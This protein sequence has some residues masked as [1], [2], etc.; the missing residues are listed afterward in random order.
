LALFQHLLNRFDKPM[1][2]PDPTGN[3]KR[4]RVWWL[5]CVAALLGVLTTVVTFSVE[6]ETAD[7]GPAETE[8]EVVVETLAPT[9]LA[10]AKPVASRSLRP[11]QV[12][13]EGYSSSDACRECHQNE[14]RS[15]HSSY[16][17]TMTQLID[18]ETAPQAIRNQSV[19]VAGREY[20]F[21]Q[22]GEQ[23]FVTFQDPLA[24]DQVRRRQLL[25]MTGSHHMHVF[26]YET[27]AEG[28][29]GEL[30]IVYLIE[31][32]K[33]IPRLA[34]FLRP[35]GPEQ[36]QIGT[37][38]RTC[39]KCHAT[40][41]R[42]RF[43]RDE[44]SWDTQV[45]E[46]G[47]ACEACHGEGENHIRRHSASGETVALDDRIVNPETLS[48]QAS[49]DVCGRCHSVSMPDFDAVSKETYRQ[50]GNPFK[51]GQLLS[52]C[53]FNCIIQAGPEAREGELF[54]R[55]SSIEDPSGSFWQDG[56]SRVAGREYNG[57]IESPCFQHGGMT[58]LS[59]HTMHPSE[60]QSLD[61]WRD[62]QL[63]PGMRGD[64]ACLQCHADF[65]DRI[66]EHTHHAPGSSGSACMNCHMP[67]TTYGLLKSI[68]SHQITS[69]SVVTSLNTDRPSAC[70]L[71]HLDRPFTWIA[72]RLHDWYDQ[73]EIQIDPNADAAK[74]ST[75]VIHF[76]KGD[77]AQRALQ[78]WSFGWEPAR[79]ASGTDW[80]EPFLLLGA[81][82]PYDAVRIISSRSLRSLP[83]RYSL[84]VDPLS[85]AGQRMKAFNESIPIL[86]SKMK[87]EPKPEVLIDEQGNFDFLRARKLIDQRN[88][89][90]VS[91]RE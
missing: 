43:N 3:P 58:C 32:E 37:W 87:A 57:L 80:M 61:D 19:T 21:E 81:N 60:S 13:P 17:R 34:S 73:P 22:D 24:Q 56:M 44:V 26:W 74:I 35:P 6:D 72:D 63:K 15:W 53:E 90:D 91:I 89:R 79:E 83:K 29:P 78:A 8:Q 64:Q 31:E 65:A 48:K 16:H 71:C 14:H 68:R 9:P 62:D 49:A 39:S 2:A 7:Q 69:P 59:C 36:P 75:A 47:I 70:A 76:L 84:D 85:E 86:Q 12:V 66:A 27:E 55:W 1:D 23:F 25:M 30:D 88:H 33:W 41:A 28:T 51:P 20:E 50:Q 45:V 67:H 52:E 54:K 5:L 18:V 46:F 42:E 4:T 38:N 10:Q 82:D 11:V 40:H 77:A